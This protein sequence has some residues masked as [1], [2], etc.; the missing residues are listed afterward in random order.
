MRSHLILMLLFVV[1]VVAAADEP[2][3]E[4]LEFY[5]KRV[6]PILEKNCYECH[7][8][9]ADEVQSGLRVD[10]RQAIIQGGDRGT[11]AEPGDGEGSLLISAVRWEDDDLQMPPEEK[12][13]EKQIEILLEWI[14]RE[15]PFPKPPEK[16]KK[17]DKKKKKKKGNGSHPLPFSSLQFDR[18]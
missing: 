10:E 6:R 13:S 16:E 17:K 18:P 3:K 9:K 5:N 12:L 1:P 8:Q 7:S 4:D 14:D 11:A 15:I 2:S